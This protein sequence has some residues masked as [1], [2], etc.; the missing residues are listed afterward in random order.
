MIPP[1]PTSLRYERDLNPQQLNVVCAPGGPVLVIAGAGSG[2]TRVVTY[3]VAYL[4]ESG[5]DPWNIL[6]VTFTNK[7]AREMLRRVE[8][9]LPPGPGGS[10]AA[11]KVWGGTFHHIGNRILRRHAPLAGFHPNY[12]ILDQEDAKGLLDECIADLKLKGPRFPRAEVLEN[13]IGLAVNTLRPMEEVVLDRYP[14]FYDLLGD[15]RAVAERYRARKRELNSMDFDDLLFYWKKLLVDHPEVRGRY[16]DQFRHILVDE[17]QDTNRIQAEI[18]DLLGQRHGNI[19][20][21]GDDAQSIYSFR[22]AHFANILSFPERYPAAKPFKLEINYRS[23]PEI[24]QIANASIE[25]NRRQFPKELRTDRTR[26]A[27]PCLVPARDASEQSDFVAGKIAEIRDSGTSL[28][29]VAV[30]YRAHYHSMELQMQLTRR[31]I[32]FQVR[33][34]IR[35]FEQAHIKDV[36][37]YLRV[38]YNPRDE[39]AWKRVLQLYPKVG[40]A[41]AEKIWR[42]VSSGP[43]DPWVAMDSRE[44]MDKIPAGSRESWRD[45]TRTIAAMRRDPVHSPGRLIEIVLKEGYE[46]YLRLRYPNYEARG[47]DLRQLAEFSF[48]YSSLEDFLSEMALLTSIEGEEDPGEK[49]REGILTLSSVHQAKG[50]EWPVVFIIWLSE[51][52]FPSMRSLTESGPDGEEE[53]RRLFYVAVTR[54]R[55]RLYLVYPRMAADRGGRQTIQRVSRFISELQGEGY[56]LM[57]PDEKYF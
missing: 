49:E 4:I 16:G 1:H 56:E 24:L 44:F 33:S 19:M 27:M 51:G 5:V 23:T 13:I 17:Y 11:G 57:D 42:L 28:S 25:F 14:F 45:L 36:C 20:A 29:Q 53:E 10:G 55:D 46:N 6:L 43:S 31:G 35:F 48:S 40:K 26:G 21:V 37:A 9:L 3:R 22:G 41:T 34:G 2:K 30:L 18:I 32:P 52:R 39:L 15:I 50:L 12:T 38:I 54:A 47:D 7:A 8:L